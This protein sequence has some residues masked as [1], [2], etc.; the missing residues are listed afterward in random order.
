MFFGGIQ[1][2]SLIDYPGKMSCVLFLPGCNFSCPYCHNPE[3]AKG[4]VPASNRIPPETAFDFLESRRGL[5]DGVVISGGEP[6]ITAE[7]EEICRRIK[8]LGYPVKLD[9]NGSS[10][11]VLDRLFAAGCVDYVAMDIKAPP[12]SYS[13]IITRSDVTEKIETSIRLIMSSGLKYEFRTTC[14]DPVASPATILELSKS[15]KNAKLYILQ[16]LSK[17]I[18]LDPEFFRRHPH[19]PN[20]SDLEKMRAMVAPMVETCVIR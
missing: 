7:I 15:I 5:L 18:L 8:K 20:H 12:A 3:L 16:K 4:D 11:D 19:Q 1:K 14:I 10:P 2:N 17:T 6:T 13:P 9:T